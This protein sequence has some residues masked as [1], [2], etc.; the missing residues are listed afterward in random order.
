M[1]SPVY[2]PFTG[3]EVCQALH[4]RSEEYLTAVFLGAIQSTVHFDGR[5]SQSTALHSLVDVVRF[6]VVFLKHAMV[7]LP[8]DLEELCEM[9][10]DG[11]CQLCEDDG[12]VTFQ[13][14]F[15]ADH[16]D[17]IARLEPDIFGKALTWANAS[18]DTPSTLLFDIV[19][20]WCR[21][22]RDCLDVLIDD[23]RKEQRCAETGR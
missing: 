11:L 8:P 7:R 15:E 10:L 9:W 20:S 16:R 23:L 5:V 13:Q 14:I 18:W 3:A 22:F 1:M 2:T 6:D 12:E 4:V 21:C 19:E 17:L